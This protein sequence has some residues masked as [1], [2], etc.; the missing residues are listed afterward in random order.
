MP[1][2]EAELEELRRADAEIEADFTDLTA[3]ERRAA[4]LRDADALSD[5]G[6]SAE[7]RR[8]ERWRAEYAK[9]R[10]RKL[11]N[12]ARWREA[13]REKFLATQAAYR[14]R[15][16]EELREKELAYYHAH[17]DEINA[18]RRAKRKASRESSVVSRENVGADAFGCPRK[19]VKT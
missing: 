4:D 2:T 18:R 3:E 14:E 7:D 13:N 9:N 12:A 15:H 17:R 10:D 19:E 6:R 5:P 11:A 1:F 16:R 8:R